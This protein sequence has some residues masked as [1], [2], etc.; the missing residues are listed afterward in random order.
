MAV[1]PGANLGMLVGRIVVQDDAD[2]FAGRNLGL[3]GVEEPD[4]LLM[5]VTLHVAADD[6]GVEHTERGKQGLWCHGACS[7]GSWSCPALLHGQTGL[8]AVERL[9]LA[10]LVNGQ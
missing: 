4:E 1:E 8:G 7:R 6:G 10:L 2:G 3:D 9:D 5:A